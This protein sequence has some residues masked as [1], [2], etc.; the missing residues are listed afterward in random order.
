MLGHHHLLLGAACYLALW[1]H[2]VSTPL[3]QLGAPVLGGPSLDGTPSL[4]LIGTSLA[5]ASASALGPDLDKAGSSIARAGGWGT[6][7]LAWGLEH[8]LHHRGPLHSLLAT[9]AVALLGNAVGAPLGV[10]DLGAVVGF[11]WMAHLL[12]D[13][14]TRRG[15]PLFW[16]VPLH[17]RPPVTFTTGTWQEV[18]VLAGALA[19]CLAW[20][21]QDLLGQL[22]S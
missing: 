1:R 12:G 2:P 22:F 19:V 15:I 20:G 6:G 16:P 3:G 5:L 17:V 11:G 8:T 18:V 13:I 7:A 9:I 21:V 14:G 10:T 4:A